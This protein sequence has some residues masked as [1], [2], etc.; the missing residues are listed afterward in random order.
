MGLTYTTIQHEFRKTH[1][2]SLN[3]YALCDMIYHLSTKP[4]SSV[5]GWCYMT[6]HSMGLELGVTKQA[7]LNMLDRLIHK[8]FLFKNEETK[9]LK[10][11]QKWQKVYDFTIGKET[12]PEVKKLDRVGKETLP[13]LG[14]ETLPNNNNIYTNTINSESEDSICVSLLDKSEKVFAEA[15]L[16]GQFFAKMKQCHS[17]SDSQLKSSFL[18]WKQ[19]QEDLQTEFKNDQHLKNSFNRFLVE[20]KGSGGKTGFAQPVPSRVR[21]GNLI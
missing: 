13:A 6:K 14:K 5:P 19:K 17:L 10:T 4:S 20:A 21:G 7:I 9:Y 11:L 12:L 2:L 8:G 1:A 3:E 18:A 16:K 15:G